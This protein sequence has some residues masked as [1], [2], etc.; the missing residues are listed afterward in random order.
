MNTPL[1][2]D[3]KL[4]ALAGDLPL[5]ARNVVDGYFHGLHRSARRG[6]SPV[7]AAHRPYMAG[8]PARLVDWRV[9][10]KTD[11]LYIREYEQE[12]NLR[13]YL[14]LDTSRSMAYG[15]G[16]QNKMAYARLL[17][18][19]LA[20][21]MQNQND[22]PGIG[23][24]GQTDYGGRVPVIPPSSRGDHLHAL[25]DRLARTEADGEAD[26]LGQF[27]GLLALGRELA[28]SV[29]VSDGYFPG[30]QG[31]DFLTQ[32]NE[33]GHEVL[34]LHLLHRD[35]ID[36]QFEDDVL[37]VDSETGAEIEADGRGMRAGY[38]RKF[39]AFL[40]SIESLCLE[41]EAAYCRII[42]D[43]PMDLALS[44]FLSRRAELF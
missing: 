24:I 8:D 42:T 35:E 27:A 43:E 40:R 6:S 16:A 21:L 2:I 41:H 14:Y 39:G 30:Q 44:A 25:L 12:T 1:A 29:L 10:A 17:C 32:L 26:D 5:L 33:R 15:D 11:Q 7:F 36:P 3:D 20:L 19:V 4:L 34:F 28:V 31:R 38:D 23:F 22:A 37:F 13:G 9:W 18:A